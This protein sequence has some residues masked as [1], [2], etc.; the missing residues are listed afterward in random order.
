MGKTDGKARQLQ[1]CGEREP[2]SGAT[3]TDALLE[4]L[5]RSVKV[6]G[7]S[8]CGIT[9]GLGECAGRDPPLTSHWLY[10]PEQVT[11]HESPFLHPIGNQEKTKARNICP[12][13]GPF[14]FVLTAC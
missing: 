9:P 14:C 3:G 12:Q 1:P 4:C 2:V 6:P 8:G 5:C 13:E 10:D 7:S 11:S